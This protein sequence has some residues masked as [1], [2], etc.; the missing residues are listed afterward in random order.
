MTYLDAVV[1]HLWGNIPGLVAWLVGIV[2]AA[3]MIK[4]EGGK[5]EKFLLAG[6]SL[7]CAVRIFSPQEAR[8]NT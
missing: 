3:L 8:C 6:F 4:R 2:L 7:M 5:A 1:P